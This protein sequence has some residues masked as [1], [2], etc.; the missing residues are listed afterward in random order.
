ML[1]SLPLAT[2]TFF[3][4]FLMMNIFLDV[5]KIVIIALREKEA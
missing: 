5:R 4:I 3:Q 2:P 1:L